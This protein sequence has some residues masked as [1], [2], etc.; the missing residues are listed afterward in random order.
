LY[1]KTWLAKVQAAGASETKIQTSVKRRKEFDRDAGLS[2]QL[3]WLTEAGF[4]ADCIYKHYFVAVFLALK[5]E[6]TDDI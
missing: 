6:L 3:T 2:D 4:M 5:K 1:W